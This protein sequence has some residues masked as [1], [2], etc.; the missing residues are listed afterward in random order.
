MSYAF[1]MSFAMAADEKEAFVL[2]RHYVEKCMEKKNARKFIEDNTIYIPSIRS[3]PFFKERVE[4]ITNMPQSKLFDICKDY[5]DEDTDLS[6]PEIELY[7]RQS[8]L[9]EN[10]FSALQLNSWLYSSGSEKEAP[11]IQFSLSGILDMYEASVLHN[12]LKDVKKTM[13][14]SDDDASNN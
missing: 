13:D 4:T 3:I 2:A 12:I 7:M 10:I 6:N 1:D 9:Y 8:V 14:L 5:L 11:Y